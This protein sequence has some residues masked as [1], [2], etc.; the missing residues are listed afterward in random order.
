MPMHGRGES[1]IRTRF[2]APSQ[3]VILPIR[4]EMA[5]A[6]LPVEKLDAGA[7]RAGYSMFTG[8]ASIPSA[9]AAFDAPM[10]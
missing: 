3:R 7:C 4:I 1:E 5:E 6:A 8:T 2:G 10:V 9:P